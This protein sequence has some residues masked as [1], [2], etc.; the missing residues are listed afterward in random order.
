[1]EIIKLED[2]YLDGPELHNGKITRLYITDDRD[3]PVAKSHINK[4]SF[5]FKYLNRIIFIED[6]EYAIPFKANDIIVDFEPD[7]DEIELFK[8]CS[9]NIY[10]WKDMETS[11]ILKIDNLDE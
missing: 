2:G 9:V 7:N 11:L 5:N 8:T 10:L 1:M 3:K 4:Q 6:L